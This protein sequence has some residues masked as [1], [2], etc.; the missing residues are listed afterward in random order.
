MGGDEEATSVL[1]SPNE[2]SQKELHEYYY[3]EATSY[4]FPPTLTVEAV[5]R[6]EGGKT[7]LHVKSSSLSVVDEELQT[8]EDQFIIGMQKAINLTKGIKQRIDAIETKFDSFLE[9]LNNQETSKEHAI[10]SERTAQAIKKNMILDF[11]RSVPLYEFDNLLFDFN[12]NVKTIRKLKK[13]MVSALDKTLPIE[14]LQPPK[15]SSPPKRTRS[16]LQAARKRQKSLSSIS[17]DILPLKVNKQAL[18][19]RAH[20]SPAKKTYLNKDFCVKKDKFCF[21]CGSKVTPEW[22]KGPEGPGTLCNACGLFYQKLVTKYGSDKAQEIMK[23][24]KNN[25]E[26]MNR[27]IH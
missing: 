27:K 12:D 20:M 1:P 9:S 4:K 21:Q 19:T 13:Y 7:V 14:V 3:G 26:A 16:D 10:D 6:N 18:E 11:G 8:D 24:R 2:T 15:I 22:R 23:H 17:G 5:P 25:D